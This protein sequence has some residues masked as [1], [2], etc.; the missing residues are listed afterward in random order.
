MCD[1]VLGA[2]IVLSGTWMWAGLH[3]INPRFLLE[4]VDL[5]DAVFLWVLPAEFVSRHRVGMH[6][7]V[8]VAEALAG[9]ILLFTTAKRQHAYSGLCTNIGLASGVNALHHFGTVGTDEMELLRHWMEHELHAT[10]DHTLEALVSSTV[11]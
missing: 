2:Q 6:G 8:A 5:V 10:C 9:A 1:D 7:M 4:P 11:R 3:K